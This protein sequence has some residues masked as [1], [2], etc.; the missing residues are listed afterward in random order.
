[1]QALLSIFGLRE[2][3]MNNSLDSKAEEKGANKSIKFKND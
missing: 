1:M 3:G 2:R